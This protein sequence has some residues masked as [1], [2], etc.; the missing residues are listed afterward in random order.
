MVH[1]PEDQTPEGEESQV[2]VR[3]IF[4]AASLIRLDLSFGMGRI[5]QAEVTM[6]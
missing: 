1:E 5:P 3:A 6:R 2:E 4:P